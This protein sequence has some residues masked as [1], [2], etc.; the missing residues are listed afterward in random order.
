MNSVLNYKDIINEH[1]D[2]ITRFQNDIQIQMN[3][4]PK[5]YTVNIKSLRSNINSEKGEIKQ[6]IKLQKDERE[7]KRQQKE[8]KKQQIQIRKQLREVKKREK[9]NKKYAKI[10]NEIYESHQRANSNPKKRGRPEKITE[11]QL[12]QQI[13]QQVK[14]LKRYDTKLTTQQKQAAKTLRREEILKTKLE[15]KKKYQYAI[16]ILMYKSIGFEGDK[17]VEKDIAKYKAKKYK[18]ISR[19]ERRAPY[20]EY[21][22]RYYLQIYHP[23]WI[24][25]RMDNTQFE[26]YHQK[27]TYMMH[28]DNSENELW[29]LLLKILAKDE[30]FLKAYQR[31]GGYIDCIY[32]MKGERNNSEEISE[33]F[34]PL[35]EEN[36]N[37]INNKGICFKYIDYSINSYAKRFNELFDFDIDTKRSPCMLHANSCF[38]NIIMTT[39]KNAI[40]KV[41]NNGARQY[42]DLTLDYLCEILNIQKQEQDIGLSIRNSV[43][44]F[45]KFKLGLVVVNLYDQVI[46]KY[47]PEHI[48]HKIS[49][50][51]LYLLVYNSHVFKLNNNVNSF[52]QT[53]NN[54][55]IQ[56]ENEERVY[57]ALKESILSRFYFRNFE[58]ELQNEV[59]FI[60][61]IDDTVQHIINSDKNIKFM[62][63]T[64]LEELL[65]EMIDNHYT[66]N[67]TVCSGI[68]KNLYFKLEDR[69][70]SIEYGDTV[71]VE[72]ELM[73]INKNEYNNYYEADKEIYE[74]LL[75]RDN[76]SQRN[77]YIINIESKYQI[78]PITGRFGYD[79]SSGFIL[80]PL[81]T[82]KHIQVILLIL[83]IFPYLMYL[84]SS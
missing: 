82:I 48:T 13:R 64:P 78:S 83:S 52:V 24:S 44:F 12:R 45:E 43:K 11:E 31:L 53:L 20:T 63:N 46:F 7:I 27:Y 23:A 4:K 57:N 2:N 75:N 50:Q 41:Y 76:I 60:D 17:N 5:G 47:Q 8:L 58:K 38:I 66:P 34:S 59:H 3:N 22:K 1:R 51:T 67:I 72:N 65:F 79:L 69:K 19:M 54:Q 62:T 55:K 71:M 9:E 28:P 18:V 84:M 74:W 35:T 73:V 21:Q 39:Y 40:E 70:F 80:I 49:P 32:L 61:S 36:Y 16:T 81:I 33:S 29:D 25:I 15:N 77:S 56:D 30:N 26:K 6:I 68:I 10:L 42:R 14:Q 37:L